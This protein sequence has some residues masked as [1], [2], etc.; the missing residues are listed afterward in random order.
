MEEKKNN[1]FL[2][3]SQMGVV[4]G[5]IIGGFTWLGTWLDKQY[6]N[7]KNVWT[8]VLSLSGVILAMYFMIRDVIR[9]SGKDEE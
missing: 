9:I 7:E 2:R 8:I 5:V 6:P 3:F 4:M 1:K